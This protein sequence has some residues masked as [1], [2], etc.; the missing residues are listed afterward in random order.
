MPYTDIILKKIQNG[1]LDEILLKNEGK[2]NGI[3]ISPDI[4]SQ[5]EDNIENEEISS[6]WHAWYR[7]GIKQ[8]IIAGRHKYTLKKEFKIISGRLRRFL[9]PVESELVALSLQEDCEIITDR[10]DIKDAVEKVKT[11][12]AR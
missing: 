8:G 2:K 1:E 7:A 9:G 4:A 3:Y 10:S 11:T 5:V 12:L 6:M